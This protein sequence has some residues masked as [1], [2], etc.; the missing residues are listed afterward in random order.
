MEPT[1]YSVI[2]IGNFKKELR[3]LS[4]KYP[5]ILED[6]QMLVN[7][8]KVDPVTGSSLG[9]GFYKIRLAIGSKGQGKSGGARVIANVRVVGKVVFLV[10]IYDKS[11][12]ET[13]T[14]KEL[15]AYLKIISQHLNG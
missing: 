5:S 9:N 3:N 7:E 15:K 1:I 14:S 8:L 11:E 12:K 4:K 2:S 6:F 13:V 10:T